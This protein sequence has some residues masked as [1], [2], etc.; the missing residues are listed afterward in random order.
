[1]LPYFALL[2][3]T[4][5]LHT[6]VILIRHVSIIVRTTITTTTIKG[7][8]SADKK[9]ERK[10]K[11]IGGVFRKLLCLSHYSCSCHHRRRRVF[12]RAVFSSRNLKYLDS[13][14]L[15][16]RCFPG[17]PRGCVPVLYSSPGFIRHSL[18]FMFRN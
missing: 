14:A 2:D 10:K 12:G 6:R 11:N 16:L 4:T 8:N 15:L 5:E 3:Y 1:M 7:V 13:S 9:Q 17:R 18:N